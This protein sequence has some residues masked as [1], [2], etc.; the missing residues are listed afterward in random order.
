M[1]R[2]IA[3]RASGG[4]PKKP[5]KNERWLLVGWASERDQD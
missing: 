1:R 5:L 2:R 4:E 3:R